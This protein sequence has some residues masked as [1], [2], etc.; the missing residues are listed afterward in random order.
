ML[1]AAA[2]HM[3]PDEIDALIRSVKAFTNAKLPS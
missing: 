2:K 1:R 3:T